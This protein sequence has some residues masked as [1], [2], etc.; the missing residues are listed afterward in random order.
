MRRVSLFVLLFVFVAASFVYAQLS[1]YSAF[2]YESH[3]VIGAHWVVAGERKFMPSY[4]NVPASFSYCPDGVL[5]FY[6]IFSYHPVS[7]CVSCGSS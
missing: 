3:E 1:S 2:P 4:K 6:R 5:L 7:S